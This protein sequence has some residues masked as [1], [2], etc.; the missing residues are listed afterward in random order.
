MREAEV[1]GNMAA[2]VEPGNMASVVDTRTRAV[3]VE[4]RAAIGNLKR[5]VV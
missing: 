2:T 5:H 1:I 4:T 3:A